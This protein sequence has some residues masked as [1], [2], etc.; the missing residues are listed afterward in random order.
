MFKLRPSFIIPCSVFD[1]RCSNLNQS[2]LYGIVDCGLRLSY[3]A[4][5]HYREKLA[6][7]LEPFI[8]HIQKNK[9]GAEAGIC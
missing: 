8:F 6:I 4:Q 1:I 7:T 9:P 5:N 3:F 2:N